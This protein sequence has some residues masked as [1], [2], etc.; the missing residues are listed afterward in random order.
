MGPRGIPYL[1]FLTSAVARRYRRWEALD[2]IRPVVEAVHR[3]QHRR[4]TGW[5]SLHLRARIER[6][7]HAVTF[8]HRP[9]EPVP[10][11]L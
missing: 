8:D 5:L 11:A 10:E 6:D 1:A 4:P 9:D 3:A 7:E 2:T